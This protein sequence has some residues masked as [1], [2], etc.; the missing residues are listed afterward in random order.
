MVPNQYRRGMAEVRL[1]MSAGLKKRVA[2]RA[3]LEG[4]SFNAFVSKL[5]LASVDGDGPVTGAMTLEDYARSWQAAGDSLA[6][7]TSY[8]RALRPLDAPR[9]KPRDDSALFALAL[10]TRRTVLED[11]RF[12]PTGTRRWALE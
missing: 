5:L 3:R 4:L 9:R 1:R 6:R 11:Q 12:R 2:Q 7:Q 8:R 10:V